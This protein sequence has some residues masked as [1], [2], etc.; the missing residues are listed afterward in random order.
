KAPHKAIIKTKGINTKTSGTMTL[1]IGILTNM[2]NMFLEN[3][4]VLYCACEMGFFEEVIF[5]EKNIDK[6]IELV[7]VNAF[8]VSTIKPFDLDELIREEM[9]KI[10]SKLI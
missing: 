4:G 1:T 10:T 5:K 8:K 7:D 2:L 3:E 9:N 6:F